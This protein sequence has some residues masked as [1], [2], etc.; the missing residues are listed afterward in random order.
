MTHSPRWLVLRSFADT[1]GVDPSKVS[2]SVDSSVDC[3]ISLDGVSPSEFSS[4]QRKAFTS[5]WAEQLGV[6]EGSVEVVSVTDQSA[7]RR[8]LVG[9]RN[10]DSQ[11]QRRALRAAGAGTAVAFA[12]RGLGRDPAAAA[13]VS[14]GISSALAGGGDGGP[15]QQGL[16]A[17]FE[18]AGMAAPAAVAVTGEPKARRGGVKGPGTTPRR[19]LPAAGGARH[20]SAASSGLP[21]RTQPLPA[22]SQPP[23]GM[24]LLPLRN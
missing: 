6:D 20:L 14:A 2:V 1:Q 22:P 19:A 16:A 21:P 4:A 3:A 17:S 13:A 23:T 5:G 15:L 24:L 11:Q 9:G 12:V 7:R 8:L 10:Q 18:A